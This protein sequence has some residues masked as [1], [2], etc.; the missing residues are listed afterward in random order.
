MKSLIERLSIV[1]GLATI[2]GGCAL[3]GPTEVSAS[4]ANALAATC[5]RTVPVSTSGGLNTAVG[6]AV[7]GDCIVL[8][9]GNYRM[10]PII[11]SG[12][13]E[14]PI[15]IRAANNGKA[16]VSSGTLTILNSK[17][18]T[19]EGI[20]YTSDKGATIEDSDHCRITRSTFRI[21]ETG[22]VTWIQVRGETGGYNRID[23][24]DIGGK[25][26]KGNLVG[27]AGEGGKI[28]P[29]TR[30]DHNYFHDVGPVTGNG[31]ETIRAG[32]SQL[33]HSSGHILIEEN[34]F[35]NCQGDP[36]I[37]SLK[38]CDDVV[39]Y[40][41]IRRSKGEIVL[42]IG[43]RNAIHGNFILGDGV[44]D[45]GGIRVHGQ[46]HRVFNNYIEN[47]DD[48][49][50]FLEGG[51]S[52]ETVEPDKFHYRVYRAQVVH[53]TIVNAKTGIQIGGAHELSPVDSVVANNVVRGETGA[54]IDEALAPTGT[55]Y[56]G[57][58]VY[59]LGAAA[60]G[61][62]SAGIAVADPRLVR[63]GDVWRL[64][65][66]SPAIDAATRLFPFVSVDMDGDVRVQPDVGADERTTESPRRAPL[67]A[68]DVGPDG[69]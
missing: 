53:N 40:N 4:D 59:P 55:Q 60:V 49:G 64:D 48:K 41:T 67:T 52:E 29:H 62:R 66:A 63:T 47:I 32:L 37:I 13:A 31:W 51:E 3:P 20:L 1:A 11:Q 27:L 6:A 61:T 12:T 7:P 36:E 24:N 14:A 42:R 9:D 54:M 23:H 50:I 26:H 16:V 10:D 68:A 33:S 28:V 2:G 22:E 69:P 8:A 18:V 57:N 21:R 58:I 34:L 56:S 38:S 30:I 35:E 15:V 44:P 46:D 45:T 43:S 39:R 5:L 17:Y 19:V 25:T 65:L